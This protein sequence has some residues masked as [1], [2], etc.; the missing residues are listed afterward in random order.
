MPCAADLGPANIGKQGAAMYVPPAF[1]TEDAIALRFAARRCFGTLVAV[2]GGR[3]VASHLPFLLHVDDGAVRAEL[4]VARA[5]PLHEIINRHP[6][7]LLTVIG[8]DSYISPDWYVSA[9]QVPTWN[10]ISVHLSGRARLVEPADTLALVDRLSARFE[11]QLLPKQPW[12]SAKMTPVRREAM[13]R[14]IVGIELDI[15]SIEAQWKFGQHKQPADQQGVM[16]G[17][18]GLGTPEAV[19]YLDV[20]R[21]WRS[22]GE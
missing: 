7:V 15:A 9:D 21:S 16:A 11:E 4:H 1:K 12:T 13:L 5:N 6:D 8:P 14:A 18:D 17:L 10:Y 19:A 22:G 2:D 3:P 20:W